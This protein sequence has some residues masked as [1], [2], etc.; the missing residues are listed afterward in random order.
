MP[1]PAIL[2]K[3]Y[4]RSRFYDTTHGRY[5]TVEELRRWRRE[6]VA[7]AVQDAETGAEVTRVLIAEAGG[8]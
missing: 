8:E 4:A 7:F 5:V 6:G 3:R 2:V 1:S